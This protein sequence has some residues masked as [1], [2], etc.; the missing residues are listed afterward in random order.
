MLEIEIAISK[1]LAS[2][3][4]AHSVEYWDFVNDNIAKSKTSQAKTLKANPNES[5]FLELFANK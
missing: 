2:V 4:L 5:V 1:Y 3:K